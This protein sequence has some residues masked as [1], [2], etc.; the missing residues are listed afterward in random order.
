MRNKR[1]LFIRYKKSRNILE[2]GEQGSQKNYNA[3]CSVL[4]RDNVDTIYVHDETRG[5]NTMDYI[6]GLMYLPFGYWFGLTPKKVRGIVE[7]AGGYDYLFIDRS[8]FGI[9]ASKAKQFGYA[10]RIISFFHNVEKVY[11]D[12][13]CG[14]KAWG[15]LVISCADRNDRWCCECSDRIISLNRRDS[16]LIENL[17]GRKADTLLPVMF[18][19]SYRQD[20]YPTCY[21]SDRPECLFIGAYFT[22]N[23]EGIE[24]FVRNVYPYVNIRLKIV[25]K[26]MDRL[27][28]S[29]WLSDD[30]E[31]I[32]DAPSLR[33]HFESADIM[34]LPIFK[35][36]G[37]KVKT[38]ESLM[39]GKN[40]IATDEAW[41]GYE[42]DYDRAGGKCNTAE[43]FIS[44]IKEFESNPSPRFNRY[45]REI[46]LE[47][48]SDTLAEGIFR[49][50]LSEQ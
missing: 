25:G 42:L 28:D 11:F 16:S 38:C 37:M 39:Y 12:A 46:Y 10:G 29:R 2:G 6:K 4:G 45:S 49:K 35:G 41:E 5:H 13:K 21:T 17:Y 3:L 43:E 22:A 1:L 33:E 31:L 9:I 20:T 8:L 50:L 30:I 36:S 48:Y 26:G 32:S 23:N 44:R 27:R 34:I 24:W 7:K 15:R 18:K 40:I 14:G 19:D 47:K